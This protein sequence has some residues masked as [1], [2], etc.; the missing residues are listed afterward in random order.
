MFLKIKVKMCL[1]FSIVWNCIFLP[2]L[3]FAAFVI[4]NM[5]R[6]LYFHS[7]LF[8]VALYLADFFSL[9]LN[10]FLFAPLSLYRKHSYCLSG[11]CV[12]FSRCILIYANNNK[13]IQNSVFQPEWMLKFWYCWC[14]MTLLFWCLGR[15]LL[16]FFFLF[17]ARS[18]DPCIFYIK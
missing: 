4:Y 3:P 9:S 16:L 5:R 8:P 11:G 6:M 17:L 18:L 12:L 7:T 10:P 14:T 1:S 13:S 15:S 2:L